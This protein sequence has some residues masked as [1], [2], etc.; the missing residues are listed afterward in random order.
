MISIGAAFTLVVFAL[1][2]GAMI[3]LASRDP[4]I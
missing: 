3:G 2:V 1:F 4:W